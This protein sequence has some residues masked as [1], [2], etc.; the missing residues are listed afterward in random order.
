MNTDTNPKPVRVKEPMPMTPEHESRVAT[1]LEN[2]V[3]L[4]HKIATGRALR[5]QMSLANAV[6]QKCLQ[7]SGYQREEV[8]ECKVITCALHPVRPYRPKL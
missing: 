5:G 7:C 8:T 1:Y 2:S 3:P 4:L 6:K